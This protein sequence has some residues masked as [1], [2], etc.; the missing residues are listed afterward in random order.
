MDIQ[1]FMLLS[2]FIGFF[3]ACVYRHW[4]LSASNPD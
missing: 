2:V 3:V 1:G 4:K